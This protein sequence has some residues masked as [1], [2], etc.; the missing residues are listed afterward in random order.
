MK[1]RKLQDRIEAIDKHLANAEAY[2]ARNSNVESSSPLHLEDWRGN[3]G[4]PAWMKNHMVPTTQKARAKMEKA[5][6]RIATK[7][8]KRKSKKR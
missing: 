7:A 3:S 4:H 6:E 8:K 2:I 1:R 5:Q